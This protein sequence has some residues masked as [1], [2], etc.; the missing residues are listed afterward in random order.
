MTKRQATNEDVYLAVG[1]I[2]WAVLSVPSMI[3]A[4]VGSWLHVFVVVLCIFASA[5]NAEKI[6]RNNGAT[7]VSADH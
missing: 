6:R 3:L 5:Y 1:A 7:D 2:V 4:I